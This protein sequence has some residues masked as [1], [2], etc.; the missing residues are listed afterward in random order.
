MKMTWEVT[1][2]GHFPTYFNDWIQV[3]VEHGPTK[4]SFIL[5]PSSMGTNYFHRAPLI[6]Y[7]NPRASKE[8]ISWIISGI[9]PDIIILLYI[10]DIYFSYCEFQPLPAL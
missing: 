10:N 6:I 7:N 1:L 2:S 8:K 3:S 5:D 4:I 9:L